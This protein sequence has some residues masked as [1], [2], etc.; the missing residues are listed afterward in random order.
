MNR[1][2]K[3]W[4]LFANK[5]IIIFHLSW[6]IEKFLTLIALITSR[7]FV[8]TE[9]ACTTHESIGQE[10]VTVF[11]ITLS[12]FFLFDSVFFFDVQEDV[13]TDLSMPLCW[14]SSK[15]IKIDVEPFVYLRMNFMV[16]V[17]NFSR[18]LFLFKSLNFSGCTVLV[19][20]TYIQNIWA[21]KSFEACVN[22]GR[23]D[24]TNDVAQMRNVINVRKG[25][26]DQGVLLALDWGVFVDYDRDF[27]VLE[28]IELLL[29]NLFLLFLAF[30]FGFGF[31]LFFL[32]G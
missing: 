18:G 9:R 11:A 30:G 23:K 2:F 17:A 28:L 1:I 26:S 31:V 7:I 6:V 3:N 19:S 4:S 12:H 32:I 13:L 14:S 25:W 27:L 22:I 16:I 10:K 5:T 21:L 29:W 15:V 8:S 24:T 20:S